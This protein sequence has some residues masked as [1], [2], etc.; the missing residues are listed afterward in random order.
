MLFFIQR[1]IVSI[2][3]KAKGGHFGYKD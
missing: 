3:E 2:V 1:V